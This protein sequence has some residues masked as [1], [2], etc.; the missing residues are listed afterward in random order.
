MEV[1]LRTKLRPIRSGM[2]FCRPLS[3]LKT[4]SFTERTP[5]DAPCDIGLMPLPG[6]RGA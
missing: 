6:M 1:K 4:G 5:R 3:E 2:V